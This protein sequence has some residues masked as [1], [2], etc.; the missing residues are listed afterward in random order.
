MKRKW[1]G[2]QSGAFRKCNTTK[3]NKTLLKGLLESKVE[4]EIQQFQNFVTTIHFVF[5]DQTQIQCFQVCASF[6]YRKDRLTQ[7]NPI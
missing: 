2:K 7:Q 3:N 5:P 1:P 4:N 6:K